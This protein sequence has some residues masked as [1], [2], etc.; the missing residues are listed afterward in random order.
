MKITAKIKTR[1][2]KNE[3]IKI[4]ENSYKISVTEIPEKGKANNIIIEILAKN[5]KIPK[6]KI[7]IISGLTNNIK[8]VNIDNE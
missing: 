7:T 2:K 6:N 4:N 1:A 3:I 8:V 5:F